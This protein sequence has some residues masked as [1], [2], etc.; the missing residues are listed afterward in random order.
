MSEVKLGY[1]LA[2]LGEELVDRTEKL[3]Q[4]SPNEEKAK[5]DYFRDASIIG[6]SD[7]PKIRT[8]ITRY[9]TLVI[10][11]IHP[12]LTQFDVDA[13]Y[14]ADFDSYTQK[15]ADYM[16]NH[17]KLTCGALV[18]ADMEMIGREAAHLDWCLARHEYVCAQHWHA[19][20]DKAR[21]L[22]QGSE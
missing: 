2:R 4:V 9:S 15:S 16:A 17:I 11:K 20:F 14:H 3:F 7:L 18:E 19:L 13:S 1:G 6:S 8:L 10:A 12:E 5:S 22:K 21:Q